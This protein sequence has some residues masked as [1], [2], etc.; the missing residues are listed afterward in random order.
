MIFGG[1]YKYIFHWQEQYFLLANIS[2]HLRSLRWSLTSLAKEVVDDDADEVDVVDDVD[3]VDVVDD[4][5]VVRKQAMHENQINYDMQL[6]LILHF[7][8]NL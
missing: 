3:N 2:N 4:V 1:T 8:R 6:L 7:S 5:G